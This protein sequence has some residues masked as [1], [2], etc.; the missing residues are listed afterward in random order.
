MSYM[1]FVRVMYRRFAR[2]VPCHC[3][4]DVPMLSTGCN[5]S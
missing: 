5:R 1:V 4:R 2:D 3:A